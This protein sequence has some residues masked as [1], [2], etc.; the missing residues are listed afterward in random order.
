M[1]T[2]ENS[3]KIKKSKFVDS[4]KKFFISVFII[5]FFLASLNPMK[6]FACMGYSVEEEINSSNII[7][8]GKL[9]DVNWN[10]TV[11][12]FVPYRA[13][14]S[15]FSG[16]RIEVKSINTDGGENKGQSQ[17]FNYLSKCTFFLNKDER[18]DS[19]SEPR[20]GSEYVIFAKK[21]GNNFVID[22]HY[23]NSMPLD[24]RIKDKNQKL[25]SEIE[26]AYT[27]KN[28][29]Q[30]FSLYESNSYYENYFKQ[31]AFAGIFIILFVILI[32]WYIKKRNKKSKLLKS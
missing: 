28:L 7:F 8:I 12:T 1:P 32:F 29:T 9:I 4:F 27:G 25:I 10:N 22:S 2:S 6:T 11:H 31:L 26:T 17:T 20:I 21:D 18:R 5:S 19:L 30:N 24:F 16:G 23:S 13:W 15:D 14:K 3:E